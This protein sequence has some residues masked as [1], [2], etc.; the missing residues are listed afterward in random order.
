MEVG[1]L[2]A[3]AFKVIFGNTDAVTAVSS[4]TIIVTFLFIVIE[5]YKRVKG[6]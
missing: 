3:E 5:V 4:F 6:G 1:G 2:F